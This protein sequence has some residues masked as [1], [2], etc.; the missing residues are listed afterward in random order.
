MQCNRVID[1]KISDVDT[2]PVAT[3]IEV[4]SHLRVTFTDDDTYITS[5]IG[6]A[7]KA[8]ENY[9]GVPLR[10]QT[11]TLTM[12]IYEETELPYGCNATL[13]SVKVRTG[14]ATNGAAEY[15][16]LTG[17][18]YSTDGEEFKSFASCRQGRYL[19]E[20]DVAPP[21]SFDD[22]KL[23]VMNEIA[24]RYEHRGDEVGAFVTQE[25]GMCKAARILAD[26]YRRLC[27]L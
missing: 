22:L 19:I 12:D 3:L 1:V 9:T 17:D 26:P 18:D 10:E 13:N 20:Y 2:D 16:T 4:K 8:V 7:T 6:Q 14:T 15:D 11:V 5:L 27:W 23:A 25:Y 21:E 24:F